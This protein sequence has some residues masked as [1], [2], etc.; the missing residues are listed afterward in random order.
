MKMKNTLKALSVALICIMIISCKVKLA[1]PNIAASSVP[2]PSATPVQ[3]TNIVNEI[4]QVEFR[5]ILSGVKSNVRNY[6]VRVSE[7]EVDFQQ[8]WDDHTGSKTNPIFLPKVDFELKNVIA[9]FLGDKPTTGFNVELERIEETNDQMNIYIKEISPLPG[10][11]VKV[12]ITQ[13]FLIIETK[14]TRKKISFINSSINKSTSEEIVIKS[15]ET[16]FDSGIKTFS[17]R[18]ARTEKE[19]SDLYREH[20]SGQK[21]V[22]STVFPIIDFNKDMVAAVF[23][24]ERPTNGYS[25]DVKKVIKTES[26]III[27]ASEIPPDGEVFP[28]V[29]SPFNFITLPKSDLPVSFDISLIV[30]PTGQILGDAGSNIT[31]KNLAIKSLDSGDNSKISSSLYI[32]L[33]NKDELKEIWA[34][35]TNNVVSAPPEI[36]FALYNLIAVFIGK[37]ETSGYLIN[38]TNAIE[39]SNEVRVFVELTKDKNN[40][41]NIN[42]N[43]YQ[44]VLIPKTGKTATFIINNLLGS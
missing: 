36:D 12:E 9:I 25:I 40:I 21:N 13:P 19:F 34:R 24:G 5:R 29:T 44:M 26:Q 35:H 16:G 30:P 33:R 23:L 28:V 43:P 18:V 15:L 1:E 39:T 31:N 7:N 14:K 3:G 37:R 32:M 38:I 10:E 42:T 2:S 8:L 27:S 11:K 17:Q 6:E 20:L 4:G 41:K 22:I